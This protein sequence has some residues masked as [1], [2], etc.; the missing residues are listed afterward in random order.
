MDKEQGG[1]T[2]RPGI[3]PVLPGMEGQ[4]GVIVDFPPFFW[5]ELSIQ[6]CL[7][8]LPHPLSGFSNYNSYQLSSGGCQVRNGHVKCIPEALRRKESDYQLRCGF[9]LCGL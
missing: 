1:E 6:V 2:G 3:S 5:E 9:T 7:L 8:S 4:Q